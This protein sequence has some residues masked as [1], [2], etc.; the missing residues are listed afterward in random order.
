MGAAKKTKN[1]RNLKEIVAARAPKPDV[2][3]TITPLAPLLAT[4]AG[5]GAGSVLSAAQVGPRAR[6][7]P[8]APT[9]HRLELTISEETRAKLERVRDLMGHRVPSGDLAVILDRALDALLVKVEKERL[10]KAERPRQISKTD[11]EDSD[12]IPRAVRR[13]VFERD[14]E[15]CTYTDE[16][17]N[18]C[19][20]RRRLELDHII[21]RACGGSNDASNLRVRCRRHNRLHAELCFGKEYVERCIHFRQRKSPA[22]AA[23]SP[24]VSS[25]GGLSAVPSSTTAAGGVPGETS[26]TPPKKPPMP[27]PSVVDLA[28]GALVKMGFRDAEARRALLVAYPPNSAMPPPPIP[29]LLRAALRAL[30]P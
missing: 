14:G 6:L 4:P 24:E 18:R 26:S 13:E 17:G 30:Y 22:R 19:Q 8:L 21:P 28:K 23:A 25:V 11:V 9:R 15:Q 7:E 1:T 29:D 27:A 2:F 5:A 10:G 20:C 12:R 3:S 16:H